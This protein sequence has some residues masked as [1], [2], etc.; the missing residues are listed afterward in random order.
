MKNTH[1]DRLLCICFLDDTNG[2][3]CDEDEENDKRFYEGTTE[4]GAL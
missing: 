1:V 3:V 2:G 4:T